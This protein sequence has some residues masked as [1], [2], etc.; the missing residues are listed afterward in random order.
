M[1][2]KHLLSAAALATIALPAQAACDA[3]QMFTL[4]WNNQASESL[5]VTGSKV[6]TLTNGA[7]ATRTVTVTFGGTTNAYVAYADNNGV[8]RQTPAVA[9]YS[10]GGLGGQ[11]KTLTLGTD[12]AGFTGDINSTTNVAVVTFTFSTPVASIDAKVFDVDFATG[13]YR[14]WIKLVGRNGASTYAPVMSGSAGNNNGATATRTAAG[15][16]V[17]FGPTTVSGTTITSSE[18]LGI[19]G[20]A[21][22]TEATGNVNATFAQ[23]VTSIEMR[24]G[25]GPTGSMTNVAGVQGI[26]FHNIAFCPMPAVTVAKSSAPVATTGDNRFAIPGSDMAY[27]LTV[28]NSGGSPVDIG[29]LVLTDP[30]PTNVT[31][32]NGDYDAASPGMGPIQVVAGSSGVTLPSSG[33][34]FSTDGSTYSGTAAAGYTS[35]VRYLRLTPSGS[36]AANSSVTFRFRARV[37]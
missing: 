9:P 21:Q 5:S 17:N 28:T 33:I 34:Q 14:D 10:N 15:S 24:Y 26:G 30:L 18:A 32:Y 2:L 13:Q 1:K 36:L 7:G 4:N 37:N 11:V 8:T 27:S 20:N 29:S 22:L 35:A 23:P 3:S 6:Y 19:N 25:N 16:W 12:F 31:F